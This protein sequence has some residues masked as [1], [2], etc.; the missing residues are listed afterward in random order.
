MLSLALLGGVV[1][2]LG[3]LV[4]QVDTCGLSQALTAVAGQGWF[5]TAYVDLNNNQADCNITL[6]TDL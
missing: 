2:A 5:S 1:N 6:Q 4:P 3:V